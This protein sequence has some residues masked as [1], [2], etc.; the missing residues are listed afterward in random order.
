MT[1][2]NAVE[3]CGFKAGRDARSGLVELEMKAMKA[4]EVGGEEKVGETWVKIRR[5]SNCGARSMEDRTR[6]C[7]RPPDPINFI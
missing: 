3:I 5:E 4:L 1:K 2:L 6:V 7:A